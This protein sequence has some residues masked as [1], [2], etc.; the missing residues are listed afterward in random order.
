DVSI[1]LTLDTERV[2]GIEQMGR[3]TLDTRASEVNNLFVPLEW[4]QQKLEVDKRANVLLGAEPDQRDWNG[5][6]QESWRLTDGQLDVRSIGDGWSELTSS[7]IFFD[8]AITGV[9]AKQRDIKQLG[10]FTY[11]VN[12]ITLGEKTL[13][14]SMVT[15]IGA[16]GDEPAEGAA[17][18]TLVPGYAKEPTEDKDAEAAPSPAEPAQADDA[19]AGVQEEVP[20][21]VLNAWSAEQLAAKVGD[22]VRLDY[23]VVDPSRKLVEHA[24]ELRVTAIVPIE[25]LA[26]DESLMP[27]FP[28]LAGTD[29]CRD[30]APGTPVELDRLSSADELYWEERG[31][32]P[33]AFV[34]L[35]VAREMWSSRFGALTAVRFQSG[36]ELSVSSAIRFELEPSDLGLFF[37]N[38]R[39]E[40][41]ASSQSPTDFSGLFIG[42]SFFLIVSSLLLVTQLFLFGIEQRTSQ[43]GLFAALGFSRARTLRVFLWENGWIALVGALLGTLLG[44][45]YTRVILWG[46]DTIWSDAVFGATIQFHARPVTLAIGVSLAVL[47]VVLSVWWA[48]RKRLH[49]SSHSLIAGETPDSLRT[50]AAGARSAK[51]WKIAA[52]T[53]GGIAL[54]L[55][56][57]V[58]PA[59]GP[60]AAGAL[61]GAGSLCLIALLAITRNYVYGAA[62][63]P[64]EP[65]ATM[66]DYSL[67]NLLRK[68]ARS[69]ATISLMSIGTFLVLA[70]GAN[71]LSPIR[72][73]SAR[74]SGSGGFSLYGRSSLPLTHDLA[75]VEGRDAFGIGDEELDGV[76]I[77]ALRTLEGDDA[78][79]LSLARASEP[80]LL[81]VNPA[82]F[83]ERGS[84]PFASTSSET[85]S[86]WDALLDE[87]DDG[88][89]PAIGDQTSL[90]WQLHLGIGDTLVYTDEFGKPFRLKIVGA[91]AD[92]ILQGELLI[93]ERHFERLFP[94]TP[95]QRTLLIDAP[96][97]KVD[98][99][100]ASL[101]R[102]LSD[103]G[104]AL[105]PSG[106]RLDA[107]HSVQNTYLLIFEGLGALGLLL[108]SVGLGM[109]VLRNTLERRA[110]IGLLTALGFEGA[111]IRRALFLESCALLGLGL[112]AGVLA[113]LITVLAAMRAPASELSL[114]NLFVMTIIIAANG[115]LWV[116]LAGRLAWRGA[117]KPALAEE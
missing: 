72:D 7:R 58:D 107:F 61:F 70:V 66:R 92:T 90:M 93:D 78:S 81:G 42:L 116:F 103:I 62:F 106:A 43:I 102:A 89:I 108:G 30:W 10:L 22:T 24:K 53:C 75:T 37:R 44:M 36:E 45:G 26:A 52:W 49:L 2:I 28:G 56:L 117:S 12:G 82:A 85:G 83:S 115:V 16:L 13:P 9:L 59:S 97:D 27:P 11:F 63:L 1:A 54:G 39:E 84:F 4:L 101:S 35:E 15:G 67:R 104:L 95:G 77:I 5:L 99:V 73:V 6:L 100:S 87:T 69:Q 105:E 25:G 76:S 51:R 34:T 86:G 3:F 112:G 8:D 68:P 19:V 32:T 74:D 91:L 64:R 33:K 57:F 31:G 111:T 98:S 80:T 65:L 88:S 48:G 96:Q 60:S 109:V 110:E 40:A 29:S 38:T 14:Y 41:I 79:C 46:L 20:G 47:A 50:Q 114:T 23:Y 113:S 55:I 17:W 71:R 18:Q 94:S 21:I